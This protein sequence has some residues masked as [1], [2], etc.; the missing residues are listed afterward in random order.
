MLAMR[1]IIKREN[2][3]GID[4]PEEMGEY[5]EVIILP[6]EANTEVEEGYFEIMT[7]DGKDIRVP[8]W[9]EEEWNYVVLSSLLNSKEDDEDWEDVF[10][11]R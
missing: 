9:T 7:E 3:K 1:K 6:T 11:A 4:I 2:I 8:N 10:E 5:V